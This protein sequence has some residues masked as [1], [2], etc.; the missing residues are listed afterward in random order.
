MPTDKQT[1]LMPK[2]PAGKLI[3]E[4]FG[5]LANLTLFVQ[6]GSY[7]IGHVFPG[8]DPVEPSLSLLITGIGMALF[9]GSVWYAMRRD[10]LRWAQVAIALNGALFAWLI[11]Y[12]MF[13]NMM[14]GRSLGGLEGLAL[15]GCGTFFVV[16]CWLA[17]REV[18]A[19]AARREERA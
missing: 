11:L 4:S 12:V 13:R 6:I 2:W 15:Y 19:E 17:F 7:I 1:G 9:F 14:T 10:N 8:L 5:Y 18:R 3:S 16:S